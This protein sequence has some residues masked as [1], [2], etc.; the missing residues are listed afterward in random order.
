MIA[1]L[2]CLWRKGKNRAARIAPAHMCTENRPLLLL[3]RRGRAAGLKRLG[4]KSG[5]LGEVAAFRSGSDHGTFDPLDRAR[6]CRWYRKYPIIGRLCCGLRREDRR[7]ASRQAIRPMT[8]RSLPPYLGADERGGEAGGFAVGGRAAHVDLTAPVAPA[9]ESAA[10][11]AP[12][13]IS[14]RSKASIGPSMPAGGGSWR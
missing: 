11:G 3:P 9:L 5:A 8:P 4:A 14:R 12:M 7:R 13:K 10:A 1:V 6:H 2:I